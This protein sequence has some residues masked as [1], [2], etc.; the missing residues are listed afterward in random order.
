MKNMKYK[1]LVIAAILF[2]YSCSEFNKMNEDF[3]NPTTVTSAM[4]ATKIT[5]DIINKG[6]MGG[7]K[8]FV[9]DIMLSKQI[10]WWE[11]AQDDQYNKIG[12]EGMYFQV[13]T[14]G[15]RMV[16]LC[17]PE[18]Q[19]AYLGLATFAKVNKMFET[20]MKLGDIAYSEAGKAEE[21]II[22]PKYDAQKDVMVGL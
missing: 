18:D 12:E 7:D 15:K 17:H 21:G 5:Y 13:I 10:A 20:S 3:N 16:E 1:L 4:L 22:K 19:D 2:F 14:N 8:G 9:Y 11:G 6:G